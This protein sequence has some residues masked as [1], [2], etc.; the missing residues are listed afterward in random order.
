MSGSLGPI[1]QAG[2]VVRDLAAAVRY[3]T[4]VLE[5]GPFFYIE[6]LAVH[7][8]E[9]GGEPGDPAISVALGYSGEVQVELIQPRDAA[10]SMWREFLDA[11]RQGLHHVAFWTRTFERDRARL[12]G[13]GLEIGQSGRSGGGGPD[14]RFA[15]FRP[16]SGHETIV[17]LSEFSGPKADTY[18]MVA[19][20]A[21]GWDGSVPVRRLDGTP[22]EP[23]A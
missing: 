3:W 19:E 14:E 16:A 9:Y 12:L 7:G 6:R 8:Y 15:Y 20:A 11:G 23:V 13:R 21:R 10:P 1:R 17:E 4:E 2:Y 22:A 18:R 5:V